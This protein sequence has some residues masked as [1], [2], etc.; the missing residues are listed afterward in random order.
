MTY[1]AIG[2]G[3]NWAPAAAIR[4][5]ACIHA[6]GFI[7][8][9]SLPASFPWVLGVLAGNHLLLAA[10]GMCPRS[11]LLGPNLVRLPD[12]SARRA[13]VALTFDDGPEPSTTP[14]VLDLLD[15][16]GAK[17]SFFCVAERA[18]AHPGVVREIVRRGHSVENHS[19]RHS[20]TF[21]LY[22]MGAMRT[23]IE[24]AQG[25]LASIAGQHPIFFRAPLGFRSPLLDPVLA[26]TALRYVSWTRRG[27]DGFSGDPTAILRRLVHR[28]AA[29]DILL[30]HDGSSART[31][32][33][34]PVVLEV[35]P[36]LLE[37]FRNLNL[38]AVSLP[39]GFDPATS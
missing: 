34:K 30:L 15:R 31:R 11:G 23:E 21:A 10:A 38:K 17:A 33:G 5:S 37:H 19:R 24:D 29:G 3:E 13:E 25:I 4:A 18:V 39:I 28:L 36:A 7:A 27:Y 14:H 9:A 22:G 6:L 16:Y 35:L 12:A 20:R 8:A 2:R 32:T 1:R 26:H